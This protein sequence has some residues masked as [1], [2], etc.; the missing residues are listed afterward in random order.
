[1]NSLIFDIK[2]F[3]LHDGNGMR[4][5]VF[6]KGCPLKCEWCHNPEGQSFFKEVSRSAK[7]TDCGLC[8]RKCSHPECADAGACLKICPQDNVRM[9]GIEYSPQALAEKLLKNRAFIEKG[10]V[11][12]SG[13]E[14]LCH[15]EF[16]LETAEHLKGIRTAVETCGYVET[17]KF[18]RYTDALDDIFM[19]IKLIDDAAHVRYTGV[20]N[21][22][23]L[24]NASRILSKRF[25]TI[26]VPLIPSVTDS[27]EN[28]SGIAEF[29]HRYRDNVFVELIPY[30]RMTG[31]KY[32]NLGR[33]YAPSFDENGAINKNT[34]IFERKG[35]RVRA[36]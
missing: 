8:R 21:G 18:I 11:T 2:E 26:R 25:V 24:E 23:I 13:G 33:I 14:P 4:T 1:M 36:Y 29:L 3:G 19:D 5:T 35:I 12:F 7:C 34:E 15:G 28:L 10:G 27:D 16:I 32:K 9:I 20:G 31:A 30:N 6:L 17:D 22:L